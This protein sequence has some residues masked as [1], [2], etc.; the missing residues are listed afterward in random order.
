MVHK[1]PLLP[2]T[3]DQ[4]GGLPLQLAVVLCHREMISYLLGVTSKD[5]EAQLLQGQTGA[6]LMDT[7]MGSKFYD[8]VLHLLHCNPKL[9]WEGRSPLEVLAQD[10]S[11]FPSGT[12]LNVCQRLIPL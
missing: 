4:Y 5:T 1:A 2:D 6:G 11:S 8:V 9:A 12:H 7:A 10:P 3:P